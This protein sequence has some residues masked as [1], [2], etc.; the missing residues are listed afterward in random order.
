MASAP[1]SATVLPFKASINLPPPI[2]VTN[3]EQL[4]SIDGKQALTVTWDPNG[5][6][7][8]DIVTVWLNR[9]R[10]LACTAPAQA[11]QVTIPQ[12]LMVELDAAAPSQS[13]S[14]N[15]EISLSRRGGKVDIFEIAL[16]NGASVPSLFSYY[17]TESFP[18]SVH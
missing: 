13:D 14:A 1:G 12:E 2:Q 11:G 3:Y 9:S 16:I 17:S 18:V 8:D 10:G 6:S 4:M 7:A 5:Y 15:M